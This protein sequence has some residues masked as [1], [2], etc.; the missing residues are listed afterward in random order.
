LGALAALGFLPLAGFSAPVVAV[1]VS[2]PQVL[3]AAT[4]RPMLKPMQA[5]L[6]D[7]YQLFMRISLLAVVILIINPASLLVPISLS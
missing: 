2:T 3:G 1:K 7:K 5:N 6:E 4:S